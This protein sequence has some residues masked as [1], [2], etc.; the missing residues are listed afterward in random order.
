MLDRLAYLAFAGFAYFVR[1][2]PLRA[3][4]A[5]GAAIG[6]VVYSFGGRRRRVLLSNLA[7]A[8]PEKPDAERRAIAKSSCRNLGRTFVEVLRLPDLTEAQARARIRVEGHDTVDAVRANGKGALALSAHFGNFEYIS[9]GMNRLGPFRC[10]LIGRRIKN[11]LVDR[12][13]QDLRLAHGVETIPNKRSLSGIF[14]KLKRGEGI[15][16]VLDQNMKRKVAVF[17]DFFGRLASTTPGLAV[18]AERSGAPVV[19]IFAVRE[20]AWRPGGDPAK[21]V[22]AVEPPIPWEAAATREE[23]VRLNTQRYTKVIEDWVRRFPDQW[24]WLHDR[25]RTQPLP[26]A[27]PAPV[28]EPAT[29]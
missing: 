21:H 5:L 12:A 14:E 24:F 4:L 1:A 3:A 17:V 6:R 29:S 23:A 15:G 11:R 7:H 18:L 2:L 13:I 19:P 28:K 10:H 20:S 22:I 8:F 27:A 16:V 25:W 9:V 26:E